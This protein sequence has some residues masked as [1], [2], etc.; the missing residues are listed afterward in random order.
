[1]YRG[2]RSSNTGYVAG[3]DVGTLLKTI[4]GGANWTIVWEGTTG[5]LFSVYFTDANTGYAVG[6]DV[7]LLK[8]IDGGTTWFQLFCGVNSNYRSI[9]FSG[10]NT[11]YVVGFSGTTI[12]TIDGGATWTKL[13][14]GTNATLISVYFTDANTGYVV[15]TNGTIL[16]TLNGGVSPAGSNDLS[17]KT[18]HLKI[19]P[20]PTFT[21][22]TIENPTEGSLSILNLNGQQLLQQEITEPATTLD[23]ST[24]PG[25]V[26]I[27][28]LA[29]EKGLQLGK[30]I[31]K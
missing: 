2:S 4:N 18:N 8:T 10:L 16:K 20:N 29:G 31:K 15:G 26:Y 24:L 19:Y 11:G 25:G 14:S 5:P 9:Y 12:K 13:W 22:I 27:V 1:M 21:C 30:F 3:G 17:S 6:S 23:V 7:T 28:K